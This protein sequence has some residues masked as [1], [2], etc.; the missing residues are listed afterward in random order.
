MT[1]RDSAWTLPCPRLRHKLRRG[2]LRLPIRNRDSESGTRPT[3]P[4]AWREPRPTFRESLQFCTLHSALVTDGLALSFPR[5]VRA[6]VLGYYPDRLIRDEKEC[7]SS[8]WGWLFAPSQPCFV[9]PPRTFPTFLR[10]TNANPGAATTV[11]TPKSVEKCFARIPT[12]KQY[13]LHEALCD[14]ACSLAA[15]GKMLSQGLGIITFHPQGVDL[16]DQPRPISR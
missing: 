6:L 4:T 1:E 16:L 11:L 14:I 2:K 10:N 12:C 5:I 7:E 3:F 13:P 15:A 8:A 9:P